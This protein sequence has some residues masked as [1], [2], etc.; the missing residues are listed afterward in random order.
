MRDGAPEE[1]DAV[2]KC[3]IAEERL[4]GLRGTSWGS[5]GRGRCRYESVNLSRAALLGWGILTV[6]SGWA[7]KS[8]GGCFNAYSTE[9]Y[10]AV[11]EVPPSLAR[12]PLSPNTDPSAGPRP[13]ENLSY[14]WCRDASLPAL[15]FAVDVAAHRPEGSPF[16]LATGTRF[17]SRRLAQDL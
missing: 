11:L 17:R 15:S 13:N 3:E 2:E 9:S 5:S 6:S 12:K 14:P 10:A 7:G 4:P 8:A 16:E 1:A